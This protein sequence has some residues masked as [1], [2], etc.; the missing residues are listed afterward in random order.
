MKIG[1]LC[2]LLSFV[3]LSVGSALNE[4]LTY[5]EV[6]YLEE[7]SGIL[8]GAV[9]RDPYN[10]PLVPI[11]TGI[12]MVL[13]LDTYIR[14]PLPMHT[15][16]P[17][18]MVTVG[19]GVLLIIA[20]YVVAARFFGSTIGMVASFLL[21]FDPNILANSHYVTSDVAVT[22]FFFFA[23]CLW[24][25]F[26]RQPT[27]VR[28]VFFGLAAGYAVG[29]KITSLVF[30]AA[31]AVVLLWLEKGKGSWRWIAAQKGMI[32]ISFVTALLFLWTLYFFRSDV[33]IVEAKNENRVSAKLL[34]LNIPIISTGIHLLQTKPVP[35]GNF[36]AILKNNALRGMTL[37][38]S[39]PPWYWMLATTAVKTPIPLLI[40]FIIGLFSIGVLTGL[41]RKRVY[42]FASIPIIILAVVM[43]LGVAPMVRYVLPMSPFVAI[44][45]ATS[46]YWARTAISRIL[47]VVFLVWYAWGSLAQYPHF[48]SY[49]NDLAG[50]REARFARLSDSNLDWGQALPDVAR[51]IRNNNI[52]K[53]QFSYFGRDDGA[54]YGLM[55]QLPYG[56]WKFDD[57]CAFHDVLIDPNISRE[58]TIISVS[59]WYSCG[60][61]IQR[62]YQKEK[63]REVVADVFLVF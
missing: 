36:I 8:S 19:F 37:G 23:G 56:S 6:F 42:V 21:A 46:I 31:V 18:R 27:I 44:V 32:L 38:I 49:A 47:L 11:L 50:P 22:L 10:P 60:Y 13:G 59:N 24:I 57:I 34:R 63:I 62:D 17:A 14:S 54:L 1:L 61:N 53:L 51:Y 16:L 25:R 55:S 20:I 12:P 39:R 3:A 40:L 2:V 29:A 28:A 15:A 41:K 45:A 52:G 9:I 33:V 58:A 30:I 48:I 7:G 5:D 35:L 26:L 43:G 4:S